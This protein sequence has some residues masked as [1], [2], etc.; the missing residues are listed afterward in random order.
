MFLTCNA[1]SQTDTSKDSVVILQKDL[2]KLVVKDL[3]AGDACKLELN[4]TK[5]LVTQLDQKIAVQDKDINN[6]E[7]R[8]SDKDKLLK[9]KDEKTV[10]LQDSISQ[11]KNKKLGAKILL[12]GSLLLNLFLI[13]RH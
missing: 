12:Y 11:E 3:I 9:L 8:L 1:F 7:L 4:K 2:S 5:E 13:I 6:L 10:L